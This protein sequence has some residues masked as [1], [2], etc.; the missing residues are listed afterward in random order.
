[1]VMKPPT[2]TKHM[3]IKLI[4]E[5]KFLRK[6]LVETLIFGLDPSNK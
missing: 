2:K 4:K 5:K 6:F 1:M 3:I